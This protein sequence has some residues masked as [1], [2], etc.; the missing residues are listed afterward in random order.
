MNFSKEGLKDKMLDFIAMPM[1]FILKLIYD[2]IAFQ[3]YELQL[4]SLL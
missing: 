3:N 4:C 1:G 2:N